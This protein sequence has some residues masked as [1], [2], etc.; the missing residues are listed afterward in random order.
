MTTVDILLPGVNG[1]LESRGQDRR[2]YTSLVH[3]RPQLLRI[4]WQ[5]A[6]PKPHGGRARCL[7]CIGP[8]ER[9]SLESSLSSIDRQRVPKCS[10]LLERCISQLLNYEIKGSAAP[11]LASFDLHGVRSSDIRPI[12]GH[13][14]LPMALIC[15]KADQMTGD[16][17]VDRR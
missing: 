11:G 8:S 4:T 12:S 3:A 15:G 5:K 9:Q 7:L 16:L 2:V 17:P 1:C 14:G 6:Q 13:G 10:R